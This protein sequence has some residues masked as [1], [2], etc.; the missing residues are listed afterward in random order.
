MPDFFNAS[1]FFDLGN[2]VKR[3]RAFGFEDGKNHL[4]RVSKDGKVP[5]V[6]KGKQEKTFGTF[7]TFPP[8]DTLELDY[9]FPWKIWIAEVAVGRGFKINRLS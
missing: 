5:K 4:L 2:Y 9:L 3:C 7:D 1:D 8:V 6:S